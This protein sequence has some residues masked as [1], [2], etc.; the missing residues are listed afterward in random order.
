MITESNNDSYNE[1]LKQIG[2]G[3]VATG[4]RTISAFCQDTGYTDTMAGGTLRPSYFTSVWLNVSYSTPRDCG[5]I[6]EDIYR[7]TLVSEEASEEM[8]SLLEQQTRKSK[9][10]AG[11]PAGV[12]TANKTGEY[13][14][15]QHDAAIV[16]SDNADY[17]IVIMSE[18]DRA[19]I[20]HIQ[21]LSRT[22]YDY[23]N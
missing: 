13:G 17:I 5:H 15:R 9:I 10:P 16:F 4:I 21:S 19:G 3:D 20:S 2:N 22:V 23:F 7:G 8:L 1:L 18:D 12:K 6:L 11:L 14:T